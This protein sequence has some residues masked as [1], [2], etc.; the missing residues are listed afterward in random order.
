MDT[1]QLLLNL[2]MLAGL[3]AIAYLVWKQSQSRPDQ[4]TNDEEQQRQ[5]MRSLIN[6]VFGEVTTKVTEQSRQVLRGEQDMIA[7]NLKSRQ[8]EIEKVVNELR[9]ELKDRQRD[10]R[11]LEQERDKQFSEIATHIQNHQKVTEKLSQD[12]EKLRTILS[13]NQARGQWGEQILYDIMATAGLIEGTHFRRQV[14][15]GGGGEISTRPDVTLLLPNQRTV[16]ID[17]KFPYA[18]VIKMAEAEQAEHKTAAKKA[19]IAD[20]RQK[21]KQIIDRGY[22]NP[23]ENTLDYAILFVPNEEL[24]SFINQQAPEVV[25]YAMKNKIMLVSPFTFLIVARTIIESYRNFMVENRLRDII[26][27]IGDFVGEWGKFE[28]EFVKFD[29]NLVRLRKSYD[30]LTTTR[31]RQMRRKIDK[32][33]EYQ[34]GDVLEGGETI[35]LEKENLTQETI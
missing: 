25:E 27:T 26:R 20:V 10:I 17:V 31:F 30:T 15:S 21:V 33:E 29:D 28:G 35:L 32:I 8:A 3:G 23:A 24:F 14:S 13:N 2:G 18:A 12:T 34:R 1:T 7:T 4:D 6:E 22:I 11:Q 16:A 19:F 9:S 5:L